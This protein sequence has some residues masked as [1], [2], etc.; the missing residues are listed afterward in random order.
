MVDPRLP[1]LEPRPCV[2]TPKYVPQVYPPT[3]ELNETH[4][5]F[6]FFYDNRQWAASPNSLWFMKAVKG[7]TGRHIS[8]L[9]R[10]EIEAISA[11][12]DDMCPRETAVAR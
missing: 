9:R 6:E 1:V 3:V 5:C 8:L 10:H 2:L 4:T 11:K 7:S 12:K